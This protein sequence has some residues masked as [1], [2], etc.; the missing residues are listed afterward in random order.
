M[1]RLSGSEIIEWKVKRGMSRMCDTVMK[2]GAN[3]VKGEK[4]NEKRRE[5]RSRESDMISRYRSIRT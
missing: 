1:K 4:V 2:S 5:M 3:A